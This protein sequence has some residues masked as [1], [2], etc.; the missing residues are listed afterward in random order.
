MNFDPIFF[1]DP[2]TELLFFFIFN[3]ILQFICIFSTDLPDEKKYKN[4]EILII[5]GTS[6]LGLA[7]ALELANEN[8]V[9][10]TARKELDVKFF[11]IKYERMDI[12]KE[13]KIEPHYDVIFIAVGFATTK[14]FENLTE[15]DIRQEFEVNY[16]GALKVIKKIIEQQQKTSFKDET[17]T[18][19]Y[20]ADSMG[21]SNTQTDQFSSQVKNCK[22]SEI[23]DKAIKV[24]Q[25][26]TDDKVS[27]KISDNKSLV[28]RK[29]KDVIFVGSTLSFF[30]IPGYSAYSPTKTALYDFYKTVYNE[31]S[32]K[33]IDLYFYILSSTKTPGYD[34]EN[35]LKPKITK[36]IENLTKEENVDV[37]ADTLLNGMRYF[38]TIPSD[39]T[40]WIFRFL[41]SI[42]LDMASNIIYKVAYLFS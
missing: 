34:K 30:H 17:L 5:G 14:F 40:V 7:L 1:S 10:V 19:Q 16:F 18:R 15:S 23:S 11:Q 31:L 2:W 9:T 41:P 32:S 27:S 3:L 42:V 39:S 24:M 21:T 28:Q 25:R 20:Q 36:R 38:K 13:F 8:N 37:R 22:P 26:Y 33:D 12:T 6:G 29:K 4:K 35:L